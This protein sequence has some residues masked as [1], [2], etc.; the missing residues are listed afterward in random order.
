[1]DAKVFHF[2]LTYVS[3]GGGT[4]EGKRQRG[5]EAKREGTKAQ[6]FR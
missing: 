6:R 3:V 5:E 1:M 4:E 2:E